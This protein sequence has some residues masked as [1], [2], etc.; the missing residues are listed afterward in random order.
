MGVRS[1]RAARR[2]LD[3]VVDA[4]PSKSVTHR[5][6]VAAALASG[7]TELHG[8]LDADDTR[9]SLE[10][11]AALGVGVARQADRWIV[12]GCGGR[13]RGGGSVALGE[14][15]TSL[16]FLLA[17]AALGAAP[18][19]L[20]GAGRLRQ[21]PLRELAD[22]LVGL[23]GEVR[24]DPSSGGL[25]ALA[26]GRPPRGGL[27]RLDG[28]RSSQFA[29]ALLLIGARLPSG[30]D[31][32]LAPPVVS[33]PYVQLTAD[34]LGDFGVRIEPQA[35]L[36]WRVPA[37]DFPGR[38][39]SVEGDH[40]SASYFLAA[41]CLAGGRVRVRGIDPQSRQ[42]DA[43]IGDV[44][45]QLGCEIRRGADWIEV[46]GS[47]RVPPFD[48]DSGDAP[49]LVPTLAAL[50][51]FA[52]GPCAIRRVAHLRH[53]ESDR[54]ERLAANLRQLGRPATAESD[55]LVIGPAPPRLVPA[56]VVTESDHRIAMAFAIAGLRLD[57]VSVDDPACVSKSN[58]RFWSQFETLEAPR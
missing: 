30:L 11:L 4:V 6:L 35:E 34:V 3:A 5:A 12:H 46:R 50:G 40:S 1:I 44:L 37:Q 26:G 18:S 38:S 25:P 47:G 21:R 56:R 42:P 23:G 54:L 17:L 48:L 13:V 49:D 55:R 31:L 14:S 29:S 39:Y 22:A 41:A 33:L 24:L 45:E 15:G 28:S 57:G 9:A 32:S 16:R 20:D 53:K 36:R 7:P 43:R 19:R 51:L 58:P 10:G 2:P 8:A 52:D 27:V